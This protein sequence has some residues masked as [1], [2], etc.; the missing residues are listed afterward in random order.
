MSEW[1][2]TESL[3]GFPICPMGL[4]LKFEIE[5]VKE[6]VTK[7]GENDYVTF[8]CVYYDDDAKAFH[9][10]EYFELSREKL[11][12]LKGFLEKVGRCD[13]MTDDTD[14]ADMEGTCFNSDVKHSTS[15]KDGQTYANFV[16]TSV[17][18]TSHEFFSLADLDTDDEAE[19]VIE[20]E[21]EPEET[22]EKQAKKAL[23]Q[24]KSTDV[25]PEGEKAPSKA[26]PRRSRRS[27]RT[28]R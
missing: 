6:G 1:Q 26:S 21:E 8:D 9:K 18:G 17:E 10:W 25:A 13:M 28:P 24:A 5:K 2:D 20:P 22:S 11:G 4:G 3:A 27:A 14:W 7:D 23:K 15:K 19:P 12:F 16:I